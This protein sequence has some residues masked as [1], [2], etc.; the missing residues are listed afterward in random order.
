ME[1]N[2]AN[3]IKYYKYSNQ[4][5]L[6][7]FLQKRRF[8]IGDIKLKKATLINSDETQEFIRSRILNGQPSMIARYGS[9][10]AEL[11]ADVMGVLLGC[12]KK[13]PE[14]RLKSI[15]RD[16]GLF[17]YGEETALKFGELM[18]KSSSNLDLLGFW[19]TGMQ[20]YLIDNICPKDF[21]VTELRNLEPYYFDNPWS[22]ALRG[23]RVVVIYPFKET[24]ETQYKKRDKLFPQRDVLPDFD[25]R[26]VKS[27]QTIAGHKDSRF[28]SWFD[29]LEYMFQEIMKEDF[30][31]AI[32]GC[33][34]YGF[35][36]ASKIKKEG[37][38]AIHLGGA[39]QILFG[40][41]GKRWDNHEIISGFYN[42]AWV[43][44]LDSEKPQNAQMVEDAC[45]W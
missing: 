2:I 24:I 44:P 12:K 29:A 11:T 42:D 23:K 41:K 36:L 17:P 13:I 26:V 20:G 43:R 21:R 9:N 22:N 16:A 7:K 27:V 1:K 19:D 34:A 6:R 3:C 8:P 30:D 4:R 39:T 31:V 40:I 15:N 18:E 5:E 32:I 45:Y 33:G 14:E 35:P 38:I 37:K 25:L 28:N 10:E